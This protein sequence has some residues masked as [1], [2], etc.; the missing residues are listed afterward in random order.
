MGIISET[1]PVTLGFMITI[2]VA[3]VSA[4][5]KLSGTLT[6]IQGEVKGINKTLNGNGK[7]GICKVQEEQGDAID[8]IK[9][10]MMRVETHLN[11][12]T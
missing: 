1:S 3:F 12:D 8:Q 9:E 5:W 6:S 2:L 7:K 11:I 10:R 4:A